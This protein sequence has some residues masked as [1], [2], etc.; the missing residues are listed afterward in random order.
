MDNLAAAINVK[1]TPLVTQ[2]ATDSKPDLESRQ[3]L[4]PGE[5]SE[6]MEEEIN[7][8]EE[9]TDTQTRQVVQLV[10]HEQ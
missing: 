7:F 1:V 2:D 9:P 3:L 4:A 8:P 5:D 10:R 6:E